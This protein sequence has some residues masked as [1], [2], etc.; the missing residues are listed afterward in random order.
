MHRAPR[1]GEQTMNALVQVLHGITEAAMYIL[2]IGLAAGVIIGCMTAVTG[3][4]VR[5][6][7]AIRSLLHRQIK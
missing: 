2:L 1:Q 5:I 4:V 3:A 7:E 6:V